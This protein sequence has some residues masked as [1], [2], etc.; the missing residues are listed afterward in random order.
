MT[1]YTS[2]YAR[3]HRARTQDKSSGIKVQNRKTTPEPRTLDVVAA[4]VGPGF[5]ALG[6]L[7]REAWTSAA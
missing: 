2:E 5:P 4:K 3:A 1:S 7:V 6:T